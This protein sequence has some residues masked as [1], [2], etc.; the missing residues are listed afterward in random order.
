VAHPSPSR[1]R[2]LSHRNC[3]CPRAP[4]ITA[5]SS[6]PF[7]SL[8]F[9]S[10]ATPGGKASE[11]KKIPHQKCHSAPHRSARRVTPRQPSQCR[12][13]PRLALSPVQLT[14][15]LSHPRTHRSFTPAL[16][17]ARYLP[18]VAAPPLPS[19]VHRSDPFQSSPQRATVPRRRDARCPNPP[20]R[21]P[22]WH[23]S[24]PDPPAIEWKQEI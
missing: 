4:R 21:F 11:H 24:L 9:R 15:R 13:A 12:P 19:L 17:V 2:N 10:S 16:G 23:P 3:G 5:A 6:L 1:V 14:K 18:L 7:L 22:S 20:H 8:W